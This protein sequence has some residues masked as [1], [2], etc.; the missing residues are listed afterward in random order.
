LIAAWRIR[1]RLLAAAIGP[2]FVVPLRSMGT[3]SIFG[4]VVMASG[5]CQPSD[6]QNAL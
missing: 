6:H 2:L 5:R 3:P 4:N 1:S